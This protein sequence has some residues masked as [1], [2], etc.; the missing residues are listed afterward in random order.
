MSDHEPT[1]PSGQP[2]GAPDW[3]EAKQKLM[4]ATGADRLI[5][6]AGVVFFVNSFLPWYGIDLGV[7][8]A[9]NVSGWSAGGL[10]VVSILLGIAATAFAAA[11]VLGKNVKLSGVADGMVYLALGGGAAVF[12]V[13]RLLTA[14]SFI[15]FGL[16]VGIASSLVLAYGGYLKFKTSG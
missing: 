4:G 16:Y 7:I 11:K 3:Q 6:I 13:L 10:A 15:K 8:G 9:A 12:A 14:T 2:D 1:T 5:L